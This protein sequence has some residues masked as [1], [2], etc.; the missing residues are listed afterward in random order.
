MST[1]RIGDQRTQYTTVMVSNM[2]DVRDIN[3]LQPIW[4]KRPPDKVGPGKS[5]PDA[6]ENKKRDKRD[7]QQDSDN[8]SGDHIDEYV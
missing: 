2:A 3:P 5:V 1:I 7:K 4:P 8:D 6:N